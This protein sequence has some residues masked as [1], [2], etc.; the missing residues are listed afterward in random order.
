MHLKQFVLV[1]IVLFTNSAEITGQ[2]NIKI[3][4]NVSFPNLEITES[5]LSG[6]Q[7]QN[8][9][10]VKPFGSLGFMHGIQLGVRYKRSNVAAEI[11]WE[12]LSRER[13]AL[14]Y[15]A[16]SDSFSDRTYNFSLSGFSAGFDNYIG[17]FGIGSTILNQRISVNRAIGN[18]DL[19]LVREQAWSLRLN[20]IV[21]VQQSRLV[22]V[23]IKPY[24][25]FPLGDY[26]L[27]ALADDAGNSIS[28]VTE[29]PNIFGIS[30][31]F[32]NGKQ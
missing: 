14:A 25:Q 7:P 12:N 9:E 32:Y 10:V 29:S 4:Y 17:S 23:M 27:Q 6:Y 24:Y 21:Q 26:N 19:N 8:F 2:L 3:G 1:V 11:G 28:D 31:I 13:T 18:N 30:L 20:F 16:S 22:S 5:I 15:Q